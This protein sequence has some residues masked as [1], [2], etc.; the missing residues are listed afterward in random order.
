MKLTIKLS[1][2]QFD[3]L[4]YC[5]CIHVPFACGS[6]NDRE[7]LRKVTKLVEDLDAQTKPKKELAIKL[8]QTAKK[9]RA[10]AQALRRRAK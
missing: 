8:K 3:L 1:R 7:T 4:R 9:L 5:L 10:R 2:E 6:F